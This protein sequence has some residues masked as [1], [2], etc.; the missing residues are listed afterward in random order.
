MFTCKF[1]NGEKELNPKMTKL[2]QK[3]S[4][5]DQSMIERCILL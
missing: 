1:I 5:L 4:K 3:V 2:Y